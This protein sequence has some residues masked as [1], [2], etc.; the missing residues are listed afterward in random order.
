[1]KQII[2]QLIAGYILSIVIFY[3]RTEDCKI[4][5]FSKDFWITS[6]LAALALSLYKYA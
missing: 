4:E 1:M 6:L 5:L 3:K 2:L